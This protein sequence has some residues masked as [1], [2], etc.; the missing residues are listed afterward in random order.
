MDSFRQTI[1]SIL[2]LLIQ[3]GD[4]IVAGIVAIEVWLRAQLERFG[5]PPVIQT[6]ILV[7]LAVLLIVASLRLFGGL[8]RVAA[9]LILVL[10]AMHILMPV[11]QH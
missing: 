6:T 5:L 3:I 8:V 9:I 10:I 4:L 1:G 2:A 11:L 7:A